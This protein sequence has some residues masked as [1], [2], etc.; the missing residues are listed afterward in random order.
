MKHCDAA[1]AE[2]FLVADT[3]S[4][5]THLF[6]DASVSPTAFAAQLAA[7]HGLRPDGAW[8]GGDLVSLIVRP[9]TE[10]DRDLIEG[11]FETASI[12]VKFV[13][14]TSTAGFAASDRLLAAILCSVPGDAYM[15][16]QDGESA[17]LVRRNGVVFLDPDQLS[18]EGLTQ[19]GYTPERLVVGV[20]AA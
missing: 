16:R 13:P 2:W 8:L 15:R 19:N 12:Y 20:P 10:D 3:M 6:L 4:L 5:D 1:W 14:R 11:G 9:W 17:G 7:E 18:P